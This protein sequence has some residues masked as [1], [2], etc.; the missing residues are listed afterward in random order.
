MSPRVDH[1]ACLFIGFGG[2]ENQKGSCRLRVGGT[3]GMERLRGERRGL[4][5]V[6]KAEEGKR[7]D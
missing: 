7:E 6:A 1:A 5:K 4:E 3:R 2:E